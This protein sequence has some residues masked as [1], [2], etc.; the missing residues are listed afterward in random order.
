MVA[1]GP[2]PQNG[3]RASRP[4]GRFGAYA[5]GYV[6]TT[7]PSWR[8]PTHIAQWKMTLSRNRPSSASQGCAAGPDDGRSR[9]SCPAF[10]AGDRPPQCHPFETRGG[11]IFKRGGQEKPL[12]N[13]AMPMLLRRMNVNETVHGFRSAFRDWASETTTFRTKCVRWRLLTRFR[14]RPR[15]PTVAATSSRNVENLWINGRNIAAMD[16]ADGGDDL[17]RC[18]GTRLKR[19]RNEFCDRPLTV[20]VALIFWDV[21]LSIPFSVL[22]EDMRPHPRQQCRI[23]ETCR[24]NEKHFD[25]SESPCFYE[26]LV[27]VPA[28]PSF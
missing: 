24:A 20:E 13:M 18:A 16:E 4:Q 21:V 7:S 23:V 11:L 28:A 6:E 19:I 12:T 8:N 5:D 15:P 3:T 22:V 27:A 14:A 2:E 25:W 1:L 17:P 9:A 26:R 10:R